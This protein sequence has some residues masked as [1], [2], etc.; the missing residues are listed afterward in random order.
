MISTLPKYNAIIFFFF[1]LIVL[2]A[3]ADHPPPRGFIV[4]VF[5]VLISALVVYWRLPYYLRWITTRRSKRILIVIGDG[6]LAGCIISLFMLVL[7]LLYGGEPSVDPGL[8]D[9]LIWIAVLSVVGMFNSV[10][11]YFVN[12]FI[13]R[14]VARPS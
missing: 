10:G 6:L 13:L 2:L 12:W 14:F 8:G 11:V 1:W 7:S 3:G 4:V 5:L 9:H